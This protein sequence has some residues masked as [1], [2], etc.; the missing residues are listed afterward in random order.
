MWNSRLFTS[1]IV[2]SALAV[3]SG[4]CKR[5]QPPAPAVQQTTGVQPRLEPVTLTGCLRSG[6]F[7]DNTW[8]LTTP[9]SDG[10]AVKGATYQLAGGDPDTLRNYAG[11]Q[12]EVS[13]TV[14]A[15][16]RVATG[17]G[18]MPRPAAKGTSGSPTVETKTEVDIKRL[19]VATVKPTG[20]RCE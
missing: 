15:E 4:A 9:S 12:V 2:V 14:D 11:R 13:G 6:M 20:D 19:T 3:T 18:P 16:E 1:V 17:S 5:G 10:G 7:A 8:V